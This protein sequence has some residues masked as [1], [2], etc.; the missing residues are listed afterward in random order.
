MK[1]LILGANGAT[2]RILVRKALDAGHT[3]T[4]LAR[5]PLDAPAHP[6]L[7]SVQGDVLDVQVMDR[8]MPGQDVVLFAVGGGK[9]HKLRIRTEGG[10]ATVASMKKHGVKKVI[11]MSGLGAG[12]S[13]D[14]LGLIF[15]W[16][17]APLVLKDLLVDQTG[18]EE[19]IRAAG[20][21]FVLVRPSEL[22]DRPAGGLKVALDGRGLGF[23]V[24]REDVAS[25]MLAQVDSPQYWGQ[26]PGLG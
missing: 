2:G 3:V 11:A 18:M 26:C 1:L 23:K 12:D 5:Q 4:A 17:I 7:T 9:D 24:G 6:R 21:D 13:R 25:F 15:S 22:V 14:K 10:A 19:A 8:V 16:I 20:V